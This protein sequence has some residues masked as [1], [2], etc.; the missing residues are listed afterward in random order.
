[1]KNTLFRLLIGCFFVSSAYSQTE[2]L[3]KPLSW[4]TKYDSSVQFKKFPH[5]DKEEQLRVD[6][7]NRSELNHKYMR[8]GY[9]HTTKINVL[10]N[11]VVQFNKRGDKLTL[12]GLEC[13]DAVS[14]NLVFD[15]FQLADGAHIYLYDP[16]KSSY[17]GAFTS[18]NN[19]QNKM[20]G[21]QILK[22]S[23][24]IVEVYEPKDQI[25]KSHLE[26]GQV[27]H[28]Y[29][30]FETIAKGLNDSGD[31]HYDVNCA[32]GDDWEL[33][34]NSVALVLSGGGLCSGSLVNNA[35]G[36]ILPYFLSANHCTG[37]P[38]NWVFRFRWEAPEGEVS[39]ATIEDS[40][41]GPKDM[42][43]N[44][45]TLR[46]SNNNADFKLVELNDFP[47]PEWEIYYNGWDATDEMTVTRTTG[48][49]HPRADVK[50]I[51]HSEMAPGQQSVNFGGNPN[52][53]MWRVPEWTLGSTEPVSSGSPL[54]DQNKR[55]IG[56]LTGGD[57]ACDGVDN[58]DEFD[59]YGRFG[60]AW[61]GDSDPSNQLKH[62]LDPTET[63]LKVVDGVDPRF[64]DVELDIAVLSVDSVNLVECSSTVNPYTRIRNNGSE[65]VTSFDISVFYDEDEVLNDSWSGSLSF[66]EVT[67]IELPTFEGASG[68]SSITVHVNNPNGEIDEATFNNTRSRAFL[69]SGDYYD[70][71]DFVFK[72]DCW[73][74]ES[75][76]T[77][78]DENNNTWFS[79]GGYPDDNTEQI[80]IEKEFCLSEGCY[81]LNVFDSFGDGIEGTEVGCDFDGELT[82]T[83]LWNGEVLAE[84]SE[85]QEN[86]NFGE[87]ITFD[88]CVE[89]MGD[90][91]SVV[92][93]NKGI[94]IFPNP[95]ASE[96]NIYLTGIAGEKKVRIIDPTGK[97]IKAYTFTGEVL[98]VDASSLSKGLYFV[99]IET[100]AEKTIEKVIVR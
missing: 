11:G 27:V 69:A 78:V 20:L 46:A 4:S 62:W 31:C 73:G 65:T 3:G 93:E 92:S 71:L 7:I 10:E 23:K 9:E 64:A 99:Y 79:G 86:L 72:L 35:S 74:S 2:D 91:N 63:D 45:A 50:K 14:I 49:H 53:Q 70:T 16:K 42:E 90:S 26:I 77:V 22:G 89:S 97:K 19:N 94:L 12:Y 28:G 83:R 60:V 39:C 1:M 51:S 6:S 29:I 17:V 76:W 88:F 66:G 55:L 96:L 48:I 56:V 67:T 38:A 52:A 82:L 59:V 24:M 41:D 61:D 81:T 100:E 44:G 32:D 21:T 30:D 5:V 18:R 25:G 75:S 40:G 33:Q 43:I 80:V 34:R 87:S 84:I 58:N 13:P 95:V 47:D 54:F 98:K 68:E 8:F 36:T 15:Q 85:Q 37:D 57:A